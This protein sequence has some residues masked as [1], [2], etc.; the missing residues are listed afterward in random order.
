MKVKFRKRWA[1]LAFF[2][3]ALGSCTE[4]VDQESVLELTQEVAEPSYEQA[5]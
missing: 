4:S 2:A 1:Y 3:M 5:L